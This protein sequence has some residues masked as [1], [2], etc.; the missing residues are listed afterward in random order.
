MFLYVDALNEITV[1]EAPA[2]A[3]NV[4]A[5]SD[6]LLLPNDLMDEMQKMLEELETSIDNK[7]TDTPSQPS[8]TNTAEQ[9]STSAEQS[10]SFQAALKESMERMRESD[11]KIQNELEKEG[12][13]NEQALLEE[14]LKQFQGAGDKGDGST[15]AGLEGMM[16]EMMKQLMCK[17]VLYEP[18]QDLATKYPVWLKDN[19][20][21]ITEAEYAKYALQLDYCVQIISIF[22]KSPDDF[23]QITTMMHKMQ[24]CGSP[25]KDILQDLAPGLEFGTDGLPS[26][27]SAVP[28]NCPVQ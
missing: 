24:E 12:N 20:D 15:T 21:K 9:P 16:E 7:P 10:K 22:D 3:P 26:L 1:K 27:D 14:M 25:P 17:D 18:L 5:L 4:K 19:K 11:Q 6:D 23:E 13:T 2:K 28:P 8:A